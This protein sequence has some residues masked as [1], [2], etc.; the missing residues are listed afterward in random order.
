MVPFGGGLIWNGLALAL[1]GQHTRGVVM[2][3]LLPT[4]SLLVSPFGLVGCG[5]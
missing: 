4:R 3:L 2:L 5:R 1:D